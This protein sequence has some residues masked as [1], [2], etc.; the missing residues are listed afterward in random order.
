MIWH[1]A[2]QPEIQS[3]FNPRL[4][5]LIFSMIC[6]KFPNHLILRGALYPAL[7]R[8]YQNDSDETKTDIWHTVT[9]AFFFDLG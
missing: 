9:L 5:T 6:V 2:S 4:T 8:I 7:G 1:R 3:G